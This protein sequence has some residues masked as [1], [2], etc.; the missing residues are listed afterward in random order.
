MLALRMVKSTVP[1]AYQIHQP[2]NLLKK[3][4]RNFKRDI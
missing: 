2:L 4:G 1:D 3:R